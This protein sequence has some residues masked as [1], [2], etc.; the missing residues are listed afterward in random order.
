MPV[1]IKSDQEPA[2]IK[3]KQAIAVRRKAETPLLESP[4]R[5]SQANGRIERAIRKRQAQFRTMRHHLES[6]L[7]TQMDNGSAIVDWL[8]VW[9]AD[10]LSKYVVHE[11]GRAAY[12]MATQHVVKHKVIGCAEKQTTSSSRFPGKRGLRV[13]TR[14]VVSAGLWAS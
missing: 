6:S 2:L 11:N 13:A 3:L 7:V 1:T 9:T 4:L 8:I 14:K 5:E 12:E 10:I